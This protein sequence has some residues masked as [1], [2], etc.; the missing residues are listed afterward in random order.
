MSSFGAP[1]PLDPFQG[2]WRDDAS[3]SF[4]L[5]YTPGNPLN[6]LSLTYTSFGSAHGVDQI[7]LMDPSSCTI[8][9]VTTLLVF[10]DLDFAALSDIG[11]EVFQPLDLEVL[12]L[13]P[14]DASFSWPSS[15]GQ[16]YTLERSTDLTMPWLPLSADQAGTGEVFTF[17]DSGAPAG[18]A[19]Y[20][21][22][23][24]GAVAPAAA[25]PAAASRASV[26]SDAKRGSTEDASFSSR[27]V[28][29]V[30]GCGLPAQ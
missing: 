27:S 20:R 25:A 30:E 18:K 14:A 11:W 24:A 3:C 9:N 1:V 6:V 23:S 22:I 5:G 10:T 29:F 2:H 4:P 13:E 8:T 15:T 12:T 21:L 17:S 7:A 16:V 28:R 19:F 26:A